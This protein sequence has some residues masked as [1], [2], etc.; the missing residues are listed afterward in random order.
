VPNDVA[1]DLFFKRSHYSLN[2]RVPELTD[3]TTPRT[4]C[5]VMMFY[6]SDAVHR[7]AIEYRKLTKSAGVN[8]VP[9]R[10]IYR[11][12]TNFWQFSAQ[13]LGGERIANFFDAVRYCRSCG[14]SAKTAIFQCVD[15]INF[16]RIG[17]DCWHYCFAYN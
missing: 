2:C 13:L 5:V 11:C 6:P 1:V 14:S 12:P 7:C 3:C 9:N 10:S 17:G 16:D 8:Q 4:D 15:E